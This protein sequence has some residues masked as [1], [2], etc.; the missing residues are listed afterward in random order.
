MIAHHC[1][2]KMLRLPD[3]RGKAWLLG[4]LRERLAVPLTR[5]RLGFSMALDPGEW[6]Q[7]ELL[8]KGA[9]EEETVACFHRLLRPGDTY[10]DVGAHVGFHTLVA[11]KLVG[12]EGEVIAIEPQPYNCARLLANWQANGFDNLEVYAGVAGET[13]GI[14]PLRNQSPVDTARLSLAGLGTE[15]LPQVFHVPMIRLDRVIQKL[16]DGRSVRLVKID[17]E[18]FEPE[19]LSGLGTS[20]DRIDNIIVELLS[21]D[22]RSRKRS[23]TTVGMLLDLGFELREVTGRRYQVGGL[24][25]DSNLWASRPDASP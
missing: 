15:G 9:I 3:F 17:A 6:T 7:V 16:G 5:L 18:G 12:V 22:E 14:V 25:P 24:L 11:R 20:I 13:E 10:I 21:K 23:E 1:L 2:V 8:A 4:R 19:I